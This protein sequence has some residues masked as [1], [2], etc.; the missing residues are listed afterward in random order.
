MLL[1]AVKL[2][3]HEIMGKLYAVEL[4]EHKNQYERI[5]TTFCVFGASVRTVHVHF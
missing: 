5:Q 3:N 1:L 4:L 2:K